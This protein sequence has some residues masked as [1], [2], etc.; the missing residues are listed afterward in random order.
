MGRAGKLLGGCALAAASVVIAASALLTVLVEAARQQ[1]P[2]G[3]DQVA[4]WMLGTPQPARGAG[5]RSGWLAAGVGVGWD[6]FTHPADTRPPRGLPLAG[7]PNLN[8]LFRD[9]AYPNH[10]G[11]D[12]PRG[13]GTPVAATMAGRVVWAGPNGPWGNLVVVENGRYQTYS[14]HLE[15]IAVAEGEVVE[16]GQRLG[17]LGSTGCSTGPHLHYGIKVRDGRG[18]AAWIDPLS[19]LGGAAYRKVPCR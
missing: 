6:G 14:A 11:I 9:P 5:P 12:L 19:T 16:K 15:A 2:G 7:T 13:P 10:T 17:T 3:G 8:C 1:L 4:A 18:G